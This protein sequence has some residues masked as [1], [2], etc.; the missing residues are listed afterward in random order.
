ML[1]Q[2]HLS[3]ECTKACDIPR[4]LHLPQSRVDL[5]SDNR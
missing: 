1:D 2:S 4:L 3:S 5:A